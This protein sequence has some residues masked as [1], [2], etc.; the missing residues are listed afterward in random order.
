MSQAWPVLRNPGLYPAREAPPGRGLGDGRREDSEPQHCRRASPS[1]RVRVPE[2]KPGAGA[3]SPGLWKPMKGQVKGGSG[4]TSGPLSRVSAGR[5]GA[6]GETQPRSP[7]PGA[8]TAHCGRALPG[9]GP[10][11]ARGRVFPGQGL[12]QEAGGFKASVAAFS[13]FPAELRAPRGNSPGA[14]SRVERG[15]GRTADSPRPDGFADGD[16]AWNRRERRR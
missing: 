15:P 11:G 8:A 3:C 6:G 13:R 7:F 2:G 14:L 12:W 5:K 4:G 16:G 10:G 9:V 1:R